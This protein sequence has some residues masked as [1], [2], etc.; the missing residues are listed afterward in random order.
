MSMGVF[1]ISDRVSWCLTQHADVLAR[2][3]RVVHTT[4]TWQRQGAS[5]TRPPPAARTRLDSSLRV[6]RSDTRILEASTRAPAL[7]AHPSAGVA[8]APSPA[9][10]GPPARDT[11]TR[12]RA[13]HRQDRDT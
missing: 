3:T 1:A 7:P 2:V 5:R 10:P 13:P 6:H 12:P 11:A 9:T 4:P 8:P